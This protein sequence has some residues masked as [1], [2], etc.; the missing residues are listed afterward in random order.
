MSKAFICNMKNDVK[1]INP[2]KSD[3]ASPTDTWLVEFNR[4]ITLKPKEFPDLVLKYNTAF[5]KIF[6]NP[7]DI[8]TNTYLYIQSVALM[9]EMQFYKKI[10][11]RLSFSGA[12]TYFVNCNATSDD[13]SFDQMLELLVGKISG[14]SKYQIEKNMIRNASFMLGMTEGK[15]PSLTDCRTKANHVDGV[16]TLTY[17]CIMNQSMAGADKLDEWLRRRHSIKE[18]FGVLFQ[19][20]IACYA[21]Y[22]S[23]ATHNDLHSGNSYVKKEKPVQVIYEINKRFYTFQPQW[24]PYLYDF[25]RA[26]SERIGKNPINDRDMCADAGQC[27][28]VAIGGNKDFI[29]CCCY[30]IEERQDLKDILTSIVCKPQKPGAVAVFNEIMSDPKCFLR[31]NQ[32]AGPAILNLD[33]TYYFR[34][35]TEIIPL[36]YAESIFSGSKAKFKKLNPADV[37]TLNTK[38]FDSTG[39]LIPKLV[40]KRIRLI[41]ETYRDRTLWD[42]VPDVRGRLRKIAPGYF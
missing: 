25:D 41:Y 10:T 7:E 38:L 2:K 11:N 29:K 26:Y 22:L 40:E 30:V 27:N 3:S 8:D 35:I 9:Y 28:D 42:Y 4:E 1:N 39:K 19:I 31:T 33:F 6:F 20:A 17:C 12:C 24:V 14:Y 23:K 5:M 13:C 18:V 36:L 34:P 16:P 21:L 32:G 37:H 15:R